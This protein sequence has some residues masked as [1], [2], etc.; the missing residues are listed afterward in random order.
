M[1]YLIMIVTGALT[2][3]CGFGQ[4]HLYEHVIG[5]LFITFGSMNI[6]LEIIRKIKNN[7]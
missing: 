3:K 1:L 4:N 5:W 7:E 6:V 2:I